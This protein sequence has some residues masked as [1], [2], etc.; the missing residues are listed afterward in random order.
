MSRRLGRLLPGI[1]GTSSW[2][3]RVLSRSSNLL[4]PRSSRLLSVSSQWSLR[5]PVLLLTAPLAQ[6]APLVVSQKKTSGKAAATTPATSP[7]G[8]ASVWTTAATSSSE[9]L[10]GANTRAYGLQGIVSEYDLAFS[11]GA[12]KRIEVLSRLPQGGSPRGAQDPDMR[13]NEG[14]NTRSRP[15]LRRATHA[16]E[17]RAR[18]PRPPRFPPYPR[19]L[20]HL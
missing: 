2:T 7:R 17:D 4:L 19:V 6:E 10:A 15:T 11:P 13:I 9:S 14:P 16:G 18:R 1:P 8:W 5:L 12:S 20:R 3:L